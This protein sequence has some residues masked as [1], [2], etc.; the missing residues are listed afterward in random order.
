[1]AKTVGV[2]MV[3]VLLLMV[4]RSEAQP[5]SKA[6]EEHRHESAQ[7]TGQ[8]AP[9]PGKLTLWYR[10]PAANWNEA[11]PVGNGRLGAMV[12]GGV[13][14]ERIQLNQDTLWEG[15]PQDPNNPK[16]LAALP[17]VRQLIFDGKSDEAAKLIG[18]DMMGVPARIKSYQPLGDLLI[19]VPNLFSAENYRR[20]LDLTTGIATT[21]YK[22]GDTTFTREVFASYPAKAIIVHLSADQPGKVNAH[23]TMAREADATVEAN[24]DVGGSSAVISLSGQLS[25]Q[26]VDQAKRPW[27]P[28]KPSMRFQGLARILPTHGL[29]G[30]GNGS[31]VFVRNA[32]ALTIEV[33]GA[34]DYLRDGTLSGIDQLVTCTGHMGTIAG[35]SY[36]D[37][38]AAHIKDIQNL[39]NRVD[40]DLGQSPADARLLP[41]DERL[42]GLSKDPSASDPELMATYFQYGRYL[43]AS[44]SRPGSMPANLQGVWND[45]LNAAWNSDY[46]TNINI[47]MNY[48]PAEVTNLSECHQPLFDFLQ[49]LSVPGAV[50]AKAMYNARG[51]VVHHLTDVYLVTTPSDG[52]PGVWPMGAAWMC[53]H[54]F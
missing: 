39:I 31:D 13:A 12:Y 43:L 18:A 26:Y 36:E 35:I 23:L 38:R 16:A 1:M 10:Q 14:N 46:H 52:P 34:T 50:T 54:L 17:K 25:A 33:F 11:L 45:K 6:P 41:T 7:L 3:L 48:W 29:I 27:G 24:T 21:T 20:D 51:W 22:V 37:L 4:C 32:D 49:A 8:S 40:L 19:D 44:C 30:P 5:K 2:G 53:Q 28:V 9:P 42:K 15:Y 47:Q